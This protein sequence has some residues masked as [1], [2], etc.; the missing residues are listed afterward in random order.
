MTDIVKSGDLVKHKATWHDYGIGLLIRKTGKISTWGMRHDPDEHMRWWVHWSNPPCDAE[1]NGF[2][3][4]YESNITVIH[5][6]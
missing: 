4:V 2:H 1:P 6:A 5:A 3:I